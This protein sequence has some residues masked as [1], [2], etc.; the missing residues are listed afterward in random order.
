MIN[1]VIWKSG[2]ICQEQ[3]E[4]EI[5]VEWEVVA[6]VIVRLQPLTEKEDNL[7]KR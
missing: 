7:D 5:V 3:E 4:E 1:G 2:A 6:K